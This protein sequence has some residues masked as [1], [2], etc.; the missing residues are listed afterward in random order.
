MRS[1]CAVLAPLVVVG[2]FSSAAEADVTR[3][4]Q[5]AKDNLPAAA[6]P[7]IAAFDVAAI[8]KLPAFN[9]VL[10]V[11]QNEN[12]E[13]KEVLG[14]FKSTCNLDVTTSV[15][16][17]VIAG[18]PAGR[19]DDIMVFVQLKI[20]RAKTS[21]CIETLLKTVE[22][23]QQVDVKQDG[24][25]S[26]VSV[27]K[28][29]GYFAWVAPNVVAFALDPENKSRVEGFLSTKGFAKGPVGALLGK[30]DPK[31]VAFGAI[32]TAKPIDRDLPVTSAYGNAVLNGTTVSAT[33]VGTATD[34]GTAAKFADGLK[35]EL[36]KMAKRDRTPAVAKKILNA[37]S[38]AASN[39]DIT[40]KGSVAT[41]DL[42]E[43]M[44][45][46]TKKTAEP[47]PQAP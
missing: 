2:L 37:I 28:E 24:M 43:A 3:A 32:K 16:G 46:M 13:V 34:A 33:V 23:K 30:L 4:W 20:D 11:L 31:A 14:L 22:K 40:I 41:G 38:I 6:F 25:F 27:G 10:D 7:A 26:V 18:D 29:T 17:F 47:P 42:L 36:A 19:D 15:D 8:V 44:L 45:E 12:H 39:T 1:I 9:K 5:A 21:N 35:Q